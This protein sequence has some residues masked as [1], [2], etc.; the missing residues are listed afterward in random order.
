MT[1]HPKKINNHSHDILRY[2]VKIPRIARSFHQGV[3]PAS[4]RAALVRFLTQYGG[5]LAFQQPAT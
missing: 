2:F 4:A 1:I 5:S 3:L